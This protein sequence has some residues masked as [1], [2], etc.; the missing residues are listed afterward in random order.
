MYRRPV[1]FDT[2]RQCCLLLAAACLLV[3]VHGAL[4]LPLSCR[5]AHTARNRL[6]TGFRGVVFESLASP[7]KYYFVDMRPDAMV[8]VG[9]KMG[10]AI[11]IMECKTYESGKDKD[12][13]LCVID[14]SFRVLLFCNRALL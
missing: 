8:T 4:P 1:V 9:D 11:F 14:H 3:L 6:W 10:L 5:V 7:S 12:A 13:D 2:P